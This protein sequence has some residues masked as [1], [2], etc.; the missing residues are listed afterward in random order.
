[1]TTL[2]QAVLWAQSRLNENARFDAAQL[3]CHAYGLNMTQLRLRGELPVDT[4]QLDSLV[5]RRAAGEPLQYLLGQWEFY[6]LPFAVGP[7]VLIPRPETELLVDFALRCLEGQ[8]RPCVWDLC[9]GSGCV[10]LSVARRRPDARVFLLE[11]SD[12]ATPYLQKN[13]ANCPN[14]RVVQGD[15]FD[16]PAA[17]EPIQLILSNPP[18]VP[19]GEIDGLSAEVRHEPREALDGGP[20]GLRFYQA[21]RENWFP[22]LA[23]GGAMAMECGEGQS[24]RLA[25]QYFQGFAAQTLRDHNGIERVV[26]V[27]RHQAPP[28]RLPQ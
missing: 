4:Q 23:A 22:L 14:A 20:D 2:R 18:Y 15:V 12:K 8:E 13:A 28:N 24:Q 6:G 1:M 16:K 19:S 21:L 27:T 26:V 10:G 11:L 7:G 25:R 9:A 3:A 17:A 5:A